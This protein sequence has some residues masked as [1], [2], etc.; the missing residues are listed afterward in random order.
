LSATR[1]RRVHKR[2][3]H[4]RDDKSDDSRPTS[5]VALGRPPPPDSAALRNPAIRNVPFTWPRIPRP[6]EP[7]F[8]HPIKSIVLT[9][10]AAGVADHREEFAT[11]R[12]RSLRGRVHRQ[13]PLCI[14]GD[15]ESEGTMRHL[16][17]AVYVRMSRAP[18]ISARRATARIFNSAWGGE[19]IGDYSPLSI[20]STNNWRQLKS[21]SLVNVSIGNARWT[22]TCHATDGWTDG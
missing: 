4:A 2:M 3:P 9:S 17:T 13:D 10:K 11:M 8:P 19:G 20:K 5:R 21:L 22:R 16:F 15:G 14:Y 1:R 12:A 18:I 7:L 6:L